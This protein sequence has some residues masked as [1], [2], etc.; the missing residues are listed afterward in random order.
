[1][2]QVSANQGWGKLHVDETNGPIVEGLGGLEGYIWY[3]ECVKGHFCCCKC[4]IFLYLL[5]FFKLIC[6]IYKMIY[7]L[8]W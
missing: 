5:F 4:K 8:I 3:R 1:M 7:N 2:F 6:I